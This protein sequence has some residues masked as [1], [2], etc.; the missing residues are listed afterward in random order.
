MFRK[1]RDV[2]RLK[3]AEEA[4]KKSEERYRTLFNHINDAAL[5]H[6]ITPNGLPGLFT[7]VND[8]ACQ[9]WGYTREELLRMTPFDLGAPEGPW[10]E[11]AREMM[12]RLREEGYAAWEGIY[13]SKS[14]QRIPVE[15]R[16]QLFEVGGEPTVLAIV[17]DMSDRKRLEDNLER[18]RSLLLT[19]INNLPDYISVKDTESRILITNAANARVM[20][21]ATPQDAVG[22]TDLDF[23]PQPEASRYLAD[24]RFVVETGTPLI[25]KEE[26]SRDRGGRTRWTLTTKVPLRNTHGRVTGVVCAGRDITGRKE[27]EERLHDLAR[28]SDEN[29]NPVM[30]VSPDGTV[31]YQN[32]SCPDSSFH[33]RMGIGRH[34]TPA[35]QAR[36]SRGMG[37][38]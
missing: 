12:A 9:R 16:S 7:E 2:T 10:K 13:R 21:L 33:Q 19:L 8:V 32:R 36:S 35:V 18:E 23:F 31:L 5:V 3:R 4:L 26:E 14:D 1:S 17:R 15:I 24:E 29:P 38:R 28:L 6:G 30:R 22:K 37:D 25:N 11:F 34:D 20:G 27:E